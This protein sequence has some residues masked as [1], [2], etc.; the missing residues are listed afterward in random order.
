MRGELDVERRN[1][2]SLWKGL[3]EY[4]FY[5]MLEVTI[6]SLFEDADRKVAPTFLDKELK[7]L[8]RFVPEKARFVDLLVKVPLKSGL[9]AWVLLHI[10][11]QGSGGENLPLRMYRYKSLIF[12]Y[13]GRPVV[14]LAVLTGRRPVSEES[15]YSETGWGMRTVYEYNTI[16]LL[17]L[18]EEELLMSTNPFKF[19]LCAAKRALRCKRDERRKYAYLKE[20]LRILADRG[21]KHEEKK[22]LLNFMEGIIDL[23]D[24]ALQQEIFKYEESLEKEGKIMYVS[25]AEQVGIEKGIEKGME[26]GK[27]EGERSKALE[28]ARRMLARRMPV[29]VIADLTGLSEDE[30]RGLMN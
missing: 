14:A 2:D 20:L 17:D 11:V 22:Y 6:P 29:D 15:F 18:D 10:E 8:S 25:I 28:T 16:Q 30:V 3:I 9:D 5:T 1:D 4:F 27:L 7:R 21:W 12:G 26:K 23:R 19:A 24:K 13:Y